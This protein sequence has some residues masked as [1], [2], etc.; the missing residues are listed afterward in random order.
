MTY[1]Q[2]V[3]GSGGWPMSVFL[4]PTLEPVYGGTYYPPKD[5]MEVRSKTSGKLSGMMTLPQA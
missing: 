5:R 3:T 4:T 1:V 2:A